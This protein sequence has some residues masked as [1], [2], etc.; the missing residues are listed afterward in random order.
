MSQELSTHAD[1]CHKENYLF[2]SLK[3][4]TF[5]LPNHNSILKHYD[6]DISNFRKISTVVKSEWISSLLP[7]K[8]LMVY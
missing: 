5:L 7:K 2:G 4:K 1:L 8:G 6:D 3:N